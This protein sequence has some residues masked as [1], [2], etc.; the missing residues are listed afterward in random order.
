MSASFSQQHLAGG[1]ACDQQ[2][3]QQQQQTVYMM[4][5]PMTPAN[6]AQPVPAPQPTA[7]THHQ[8]VSSCATLM[9]R[10][11]IIKPMFRFRVNVYI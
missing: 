2:Q 1:D 4:P 9:F 5:S 7:N 10:F 3:Q 8:Q 11:Q 6:Q